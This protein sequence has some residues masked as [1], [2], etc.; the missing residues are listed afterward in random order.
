MRA[1]RTMAL[2]LA[3]AVSLGAQGKVFLTTSEALQ[4]AFP[5]CE[6]QRTQRVLTAA[7][8]AQVK[9]LA[10]HKP[11][12]SLVVGYEAR[13][14]G[15]L[16]G[17]AYFDRHRVRSRSQLLMV[18][19]DPQGKVLRVEVLAFH[20]PT[21]YLPHGRFFA[22]FAGRALDRRLR[23]GR[24]VRGVAGATLTVDATVAAVRRVLAT[25][26]V[27]T[28][29]AEHAEHADRADQAGSKVSDSRS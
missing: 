5:K 11:R 21:E 17:T 8:K 2:S 3:A 23:T 24:A 13:R 28:A 19:V 14:A 20:E 12:R 10:G 29:R 18:A 4:L 1:L 27:L 6:I 26:R 25:H 15:K 7:M 16:V 9:R 22:Q